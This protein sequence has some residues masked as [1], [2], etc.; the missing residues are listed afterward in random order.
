MSIDR[1]LLIWIW[2]GVVYIIANLRK[3]G[4]ENMVNTSAL[5][6]AVGAVQTAADAAIAAGVGTADVAG[7]AAIDAATAQ[8]N[9]IATALAAA[10]PAPIPTP[11]P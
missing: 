10:T 2:V 1:M 8:L 4:D 5:T 7:Q 3:R 11:T 6:T 9:A